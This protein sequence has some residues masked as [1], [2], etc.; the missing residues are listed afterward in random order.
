MNRVTKTVILA[1]MLASLLFPGLAMA[2][3]A[4]PAPDPAGGSQIGNLALDFELQDLDG[5][6][7]SLTGL[8][9]AT[10]MLNFW[11]S[12]CDPCRDEM[13]FIQEIYEDEEWSGKGLVILAI[14]MGEDSGQVKRFMEVNGLSLPV[15]LDA[16][17]D[18]ARK[19]NIRGIPT[20]LF[21]DKDGIIKDIKNGPLT[22]KAQ[23]ERILTRVM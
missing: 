19:Y 13:P 6:T 15:L 11:T 5:Q 1:I 23:I 7:V 20:T 8:R 14:N 22:S 3:C 17:Q 16:S 4:G 21:I 2:G 9:G 10:V 18:V 12:W